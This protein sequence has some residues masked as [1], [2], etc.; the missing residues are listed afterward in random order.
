MPKRTI[1]GEVCVDLSVIIPAF[2]EADT[3]AKTVADLA[4]L[5]A[6][7]PDVEIIV[8]NDGSSDATLDEASAAATAYGNCR[9]VSY[10]ANRG[11]GY[12]LRRGF[13]EARGR[14]VAFIDADGEVAPK[15]LAALLHHQREA[16]VS[17]VVGK[18]AVRGARPGYRQMM[19]HTVR[20]VGGA[21]FKLPVSDSQ[22]GVKLFVKSDVA[23]LVAYCKEAG[24][25]FDLELLALAHYRGLPIH[26]IPVEVTILRT[27]RIT[28]LTGI[29]YLGRMARLVLSRDRLVHYASP[30]SV[31]Q[32]APLT[33]S[34]LSVVLQESLG[35]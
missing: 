33:S 24:Y 14:L 1:K 8:V 25:L 28:L 4:A 29:T 20:F 21:L 15:A 6:A 7:T 3:L 2:N 30:P 10:A 16:D 18:R 19:T 5:F 27:S 11:K 23:D 22:T 35:E 26:E 31:S 13:A 12:A 9:V 17:V 32:A 34:L